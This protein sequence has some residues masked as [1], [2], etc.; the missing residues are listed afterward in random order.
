M[1]LSSYFLSL[2]SRLNRRDLP[3]LPKLSRLQKSLFIISCIFIF[4]LITV[5]GSRIT[6]KTLAADK[7]E[8]RYQR[9]AIKAGGN[10]ESWFGSGIFTTAFNF[11]NIFTNI[12]DIPESL[13]TSIENGQPIASSQWVPGGVTGNLSGMIATLNY[14]QASGIEYI[15]SVKNNFLGKPAYAQSGVGFAG[16]QPLLPL[17][18]GFRNIVYILSSIIFIAI[19]IMIIL[20]VKISP[21]A[22]V[23]IQNAIPGLIT[24]LILVTFS[25]AI[26]G[27]AIDL[28]YLFAGLIV[29]MFYTI[30]GTAFGGNLLNPW[31]IFNNINPIS[32]LGNTI[33]LGYQQFTSSSPYTL[34][35]LTN[36][37][38]N[39]Y[40][41]LV[42]HAM[43]SWALY[44]LS[45]MVSSV[46]LGTLGGGIFNLIA[47]GVGNDV[48]RIA[49]GTVGG[50]L[51]GT[52]GGV[53]ISLLMTVI[54]TWW[55]IKLFFGLIKTYVTVIFK[56]IV[57]PLEIG[58]GA[59]PGAKMGFSS[60]IT[61]LV[62]YISVFPITTIFLVL[63]NLIGE[64]ILSDAGKSLWIPGQLL[65]GAAGSNWWS[66]NAIVKAALGLAGLGLV[67]KMPD[68]IPQFIFNLKPS[69]WTQAMGQE[70]SSLGKSTAI[71]LVKGTIAN[72]A[73]EMIASGTGTI[74][75]TVKRA[76]E[77]VLGPGAGPQ[78][79]EAVK[80]L[81]K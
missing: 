75:G 39:T 45:G 69:P 28:I 7:S 16:L 11:L 9:D 48:G 54:M 79:G 26:A 57:A 12:I 29:A 19:G 80:Q 44:A 14:P 64:T 31:R 40:Q 71:K 24:T 27:L 18:R 15:A 53:V 1:S 52:I 56:I 10:V 65:I 2:I 49:F 32:W 68:M 21:Q 63:L 60:W 70:Y 3:L 74:G 8:I 23:T 4:T 22:V 34:Q 36:P 42:Y 41:S 13:L 77:K 33:Q 38:F 55:L 58:L 50:V 78:V 35:N 62:T 73:G 17:W 46:V 51:G 66:A 67:S 61:D 30:T 47:G 20:R 72:R 76:S 59:F 25:Y 81:G 37:S 6:T 43:P 5:Y